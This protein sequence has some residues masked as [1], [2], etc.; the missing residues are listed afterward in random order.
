MEKPPTNS[1]G[2]QVSRSNNRGPAH[3]SHNAP[4]RQNL[5]R[6]RGKGGKKTT[7]QFSQAEAIMGKAAADEFKKSM[8]N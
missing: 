8:G 7:A 6:G 5:Q 2:G 4:S 3:L 1:G